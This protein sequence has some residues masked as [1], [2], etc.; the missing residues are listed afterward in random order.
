MKSIDKLCLIFN[1]PTYYN[2]PTYLLIEKYYNCDWYFGDWKTDI[3][4]MDTDQFKR[5]LFLKVNHQNSK[6]YTQSRMI[7]ILRNKEYQTFLMTGETRNLSFW[8]FLFVRNLFYRNKRIYLWTHGWY[9]KETRIEALIKKWMFR[10]VTGIFTYGDYAKKLLMKEGFPETKIFPIHNALHYE[11]QLALRNRMQASDFYQ[12]HFGNS[13]P[14]LLFIGRLTKVKQL[15]MLVNAVANLKQQGKLY[16]LVFVGDGTERGK[17]ETLVNDRGINDS[18]W[19]YGECYE[20]NINAE[21]VYNADLCVA[22]GNVGLT[23][24]HSLMFGTPVI[25]HD[26]FAYQMPEFEAIKN[27]LTGNFYHQGSQESLEEKISLWFEQYGRDRETIRN[28]CFMEI[29]KNWTPDFQ[30][31]V[32]KNNIVIA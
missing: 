8:W 6:L 30:L 24:M 20:E 19:F 31:N 10:S 13:N 18:V 9:G 5:C 32:I 23:A 4:K 28:N 27:G 2:E 17:L 26:N 1:V 16:N 3:K 7:S 11:Q 22:P 21:L 15:D 14:V 12:N 25:T 29:D